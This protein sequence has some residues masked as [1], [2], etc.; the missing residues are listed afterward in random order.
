M[1]LEQSL[2]REPATKTVEIQ[3]VYRYIENKILF[4]ESET[5][6]DP[7]TPDYLVPEGQEPE[8]LEIAD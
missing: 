6:T 8:V 1:E 7:Y 4:R 3:T 5:Q 2:H